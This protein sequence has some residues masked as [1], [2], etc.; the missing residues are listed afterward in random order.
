MGGYG[1]MRGNLSDIVELQHAYVIL[2]RHVPSTLF[3]LSALVRLSA[4]PI[5]RYHF[6]LAISS[7]CQI[8][9][10]LSQT[11]AAA[12]N[13]VIMPTVSLRYRTLTQLRF[14]LALVLL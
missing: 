2:I 1:V 9:Y 5:H 14:I 10:N 11:Q 3:K 13:F 4:D 6:K 7:P 12:L 8:R